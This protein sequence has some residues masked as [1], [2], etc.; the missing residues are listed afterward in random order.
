MIYKWKRHY[1]LFYLRHKT[2]WA[3]NLKCYTTVAKICIIHLF[4]DIIFQIGAESFTTKQFFALY[5]LPRIESW[6]LL[7]H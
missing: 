1:S 2:S 6:Y 3:I 4:L 7:K 5:Q